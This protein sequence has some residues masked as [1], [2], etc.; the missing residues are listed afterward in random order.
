MRSRLS[1]IF[2]LLVALAA[3]AASAQPIIT[4][5][6]D[7]TGDGGG[8]LLDGP[9]GIAVDGSGNVYV[10]GLDSHNAF[11]I[12]PGGVI[13]EIIDSTGDGVNEL[14]NPVGI[15]VDKS[16]NVYTA[17]LTSSNAFKITPGAVIT[18]II[19]STGDGGGNVL[20]GALSIAVDESGSVY[21]TGA[22]SDN[23]FK[24]DLSPIFDDGFES[25]DTSAWSSTVP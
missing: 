6:I 18:E 13:T 15:T 19:D 16:E 10:T 8:A 14:E 9:F 23:A 25:G 4:E 17:G 7:A 2:A 22:E 21:V 1:G 24:V 11:K 12:T 5:I 20:D 3:S